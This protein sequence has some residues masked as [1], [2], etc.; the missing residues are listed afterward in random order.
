MWAQTYDGPVRWVI[1]DDGPE[2]QP[3]TMSREN[4][5]IEVHRRRPF[6]SPGENTQGANLRYGLEQIE[7]KEAL[8]II[9]DDDWY[10]PDWLETVA[11]ELTTAC[12]VG[13]ITAHYYHLSSRRYRNMLNLHHSSLCSTAMRGDALELFR[14]IVEKQAEFYDILL[15]QKYKQ[16]RLFYGR[17][18]IGMKGL[19]GRTGIGSGHDRRFHGELDRDGSVLRSWVGEGAAHHYFMVGKQK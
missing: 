7:S 4:W 19:P 3:I 15:Y 1:V 6:W 9:E 13:E 8:V 10:K 18:V 5:F 11:H 17:S 2:A 12:L 16:G 14:R